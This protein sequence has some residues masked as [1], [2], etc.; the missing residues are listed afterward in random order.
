MDYIRHVAETLGGHPAVYALLLEEAPTGGA[1]FGIDRWKSVTAA[2][3]GRLQ[4]AAWTED[5][6]QYAVKVWQMAQYTAYVRELAAVVRKA[7]ARLKTTISFHLDALLPTEALVHFQDTARMLDFAIIDAGT[8]GGYDP[9]WRHGLTRCLAGMAATLTDR[10]IWMVAGSHVPQDRYRPCLREI[11][12]WT[13]QVCEQGVCAVGWHGWDD[14]FW[15]DGYPVRGMALAERYPE[16]WTTILGLSRALAGQEMKKPAPSP[17]ACLLSYDSCLHRLM[18]ADGVATGM[19]LSEYARLVPRYVSDTQVVEE[20]M[21]QKCSILFTTPCPSARE[22]LVERLMD[23][24]ARGGWIVASGDDFSLDEQRRPAERRRMLGVREERALAN[25]D[26][27][28]LTG[29]LPGLAEGTSLATAWNRIRL[30]AME[31]PMRVLGRWGDGAPAIVLKPHGK[32]GSLYIGTD[33]YQAAVAAGSREEWGRLFQSIA[34]P[35]TL[36][37]LIG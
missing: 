12:E 27:I 3:E 25:E 2:L 11:R 23:F 24:M 1:Q 9:L 20:G 36:K 6:Y 14:T 22:A 5:G 8:A 10:D 37:R 33:P 18:G 30:T 28:L 17:Y 21:P 31:D 15:A 26:R 7:R 34:A 13:Q 19:A 35:G 16:H 4:A 29:P 32:G